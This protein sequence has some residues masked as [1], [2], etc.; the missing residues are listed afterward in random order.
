MVTSR[1]DLSTATLPLRGDHEVTECETEVVTPPDTLFGVSID[2]YAVEGGYDTE[3]GPASTFGAAQSLGRVPPSLRTAATYEHLDDLVRHAA[4]LG[5]SQVRVTMEWARL[6][7]RPD[8]RDSDALEHYLSALRVARDEGLECVV[9]LCDA[10]LP[11]WL[12][13]EPWL[14]PWAPL[15]F[16]SHAAW[17]AEHLDGLARGILTFRC[18]NTAVREG[19]ETGQRP[20][21]RR[22]A[23]DDARCALDGILVAHQLACA[24][25]AEVAPAPTRAL[26][27]E[28]TRSYDDDAAWRDLAAGLV[29]PVLRAARRDRWEVGPTRPR[30][31]SRRPDTT[32]VSTS[33]W[34][35]TPDF[36]W[37][38][39]GTDEELLARALSFADGAVRTVELGTST[40]WDDD[41]RARVQRLTGG[42]NGASTVHLFGL[43]STT[44]PLDAPVG[45]L[46]VDQHDG[47]WSVHVSGERTAAIRSAVGG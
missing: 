35:D 5:C 4:A 34:R 7:R 6:E 18:P 10:A 29:D 44:G 16:A 42:P 13:N 23:S 38:L 2:G 33:R 45:L 1:V 26:L 43:V 22:G 12:G 27:F 17:I 36:E 25:I 21:F 24:S 28:A 14:A 41:V 37:W 46:D 8:Q 3:T 39:S 40:S 20:P 11:S 31:S 19:W 32:L 47:G 15:R 9:V 30:R